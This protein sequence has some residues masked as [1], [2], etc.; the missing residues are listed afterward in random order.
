LK[1]EIEEKLS[2]DEIVY[3]SKGFVYYKNQWLSPQ[4]YEK[5]LYAEGYVKYNNEFV[6]YHTLDK[7][8]TNKTKPLVTTF[9]NEK[10]KD[11]MVHSKNIKLIDISLEENSSAAS[12]YAVD[13]KWEA[14]T[15]KGL[16]EGFCSIVVSYNV[17]ADKWY[18]VK[19]CE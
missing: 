1:K 10:F 6:K 16:S 17:D 9:L 7:I 19:G 14:W 12:N 2:R 8:I 18:L 15:F 11:T 4:A 13:Y 5:I 3:G